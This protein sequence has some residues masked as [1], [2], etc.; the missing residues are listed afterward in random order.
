MAKTAGEGGGAKKRPGL[1]GDNVVRPRPSASV[2]AKPSAGRVTRSAVPKVVNKQ[3][4]MSRTP[5]PP[6]GKRT[7]PPAGPSPS[8]R[9]SE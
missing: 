1:V 2:K 3:V 5:T 8:K 6:Q 9:R 4:T 7:P